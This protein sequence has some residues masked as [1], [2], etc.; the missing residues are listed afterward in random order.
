MQS[1]TFSELLRLSSPETAPCVSIYLSTHRKGMEINE[2][3]DQLAFKQAIKEAES[4]LRSSGLDDSRIAKMLKPANVLLSDKKFWHHML[5]SLVLF[6]SPDEFNFYLLPYSFDPLVDVSSEFYL[7]PLITQIEAEDHYLLLKLSKKEVKL[8]DITRTESNEV[9]TL[10]LLPQNLRAVAGS[11]VE[12][13]SLQFH[14]TNPRTGTSQFH[15]H[16]AGKDDEGTEL[17]EYFREI[18]RGLNKLLPDQSAKLL[19][20]TVN[21]QF[22]EYKAVS[23]YR[24]LFP[25]SIPG[26]PDGVAINTLAGKGW[27]IIDE[28]RKKEIHEQ[29]NRYREMSTKENTNSRFSE[30]IPACINGRVDTLFVAEGARQFGIYN[31]EL[32]RVELHDSR[33]ADDIELINHA[34]IDVIR[35]KGTVISLNRDTMPEPESPVNAVYRY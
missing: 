7:L 34:A 12:E 11:D 26:N 33:A 4:A 25:E 5:D 2:H 29:V 6:V 30:V 28:E 22:G 1:L 16:G 23:K 8:Y 9:D 20:A 19:I 10:G 21:G 13:E 14:S 31:P 17:I 35:Q 3:Q 18:D 27:K 24:S 15:G 32:N